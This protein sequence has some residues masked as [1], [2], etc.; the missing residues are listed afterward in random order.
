MLLLNRYKYS[1]VEPIELE[2]P[3]KWRMG[4]AVVIKNQY[5]VPQLLLSR[6]DATKRYI[7]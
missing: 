1:G 3:P 5:R 2:K 6:E 4:Q 7:F